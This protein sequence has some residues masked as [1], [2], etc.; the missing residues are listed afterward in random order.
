M[1]K[2][3]TDVV[4]KNAIA[5]NPEYVVAVFTAPEGNDHAGNTV[6]NLINGGLIV[7]ES[8]VDVV[9]AINGELK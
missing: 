6:I 2:Y 8:D 5:I 1:L 9:G 3:F 7:S 4:T